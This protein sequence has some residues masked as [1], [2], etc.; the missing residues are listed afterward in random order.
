M[1]DKM[2]SQVI[3]TWF[4]GLISVKLKKDSLNRVSINYLDSSS[5]G[6]TGG[7]L[8]LMACNDDSELM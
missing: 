3:W 1:D 2:T 7:K 8:A 5:S 6:R 4:S